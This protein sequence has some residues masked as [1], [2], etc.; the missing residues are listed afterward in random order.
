MIPFTYDVIEARREWAKALR[1]GEYEQTS[2]TLVRFKAAYDADGDYFE[3][4]DEVEGYCCLGV[5]CQLRD[6]DQD[7]AWWVGN[8]MPPDDLREAAGLGDDLAEE[9]DPAMFYAQLNDGQRYT[10]DM[11]ARVVEERTL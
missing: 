7:L 2:G 6:P 1:S 10:F 11:I 3:D 9:R 5:L 8:E 4:T